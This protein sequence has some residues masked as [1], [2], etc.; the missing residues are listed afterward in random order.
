MEMTH[1]GTCKGL[2]L[3]ITEKHAN[4]CIECGVWERSGG[5]LHECRKRRRVPILQRGCGAEIHLEL[6]F[7]SSL[8]LNNLGSAGLV[9]L[10][11]LR[12]IRPSSQSRRAVQTVLTHRGGMLHGTCLCSC[13]SPRSVMTYSQLGW[14]TPV[15]VRVAGARTFVLVWVLALVL[16]LVLGALLERGEKTSSTID[17]GTVVDPTTPS[18]VP[19]RT[20]VSTR[21]PCVH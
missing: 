5:L 7:Y 16:A 2:L 3:I 21:T 15:T 13:S 9:T 12:C 17:T 18:T 1:T 19:V 10:L 6:S 11:S 8:L 14:T 4:C 20:S